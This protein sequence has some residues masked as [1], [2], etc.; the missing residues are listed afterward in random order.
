MDLRSDL[1]VPDLSSVKASVNQIELSDTI[2][3]EILPKE[4][5]NKQQQQEVTKI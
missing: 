2:T 1:A 3:P 5:F 4:K